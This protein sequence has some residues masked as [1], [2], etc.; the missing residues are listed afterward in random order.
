MGH[1]L[2]CVAHGFNEAYAKKRVVKKKILIKKI[3]LNKIEI[4]IFFSRE[5]ENF[6][7]PL[8]WPI[9]SNACKQIRAI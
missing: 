8:L 2:G 7:N 9:T 4:A 1:D 3:I 5:N 6:G